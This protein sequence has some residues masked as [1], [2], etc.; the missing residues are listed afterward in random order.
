MCDLKTII[1][2]V[3]FVLVVI[4]STSPGVAVSQTLWVSLEVHSRHSFEVTSEWQLS[5]VSQT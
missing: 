5:Y 4:P 1:E 2:H 3:P